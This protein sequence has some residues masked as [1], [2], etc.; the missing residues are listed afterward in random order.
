[1]DYALIE[2]ELTN[3]VEDVSKAAGWTVDRKIVLAIASKFVAS[4]K[5]F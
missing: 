2:N 5:T 1:M 3:T 4:G